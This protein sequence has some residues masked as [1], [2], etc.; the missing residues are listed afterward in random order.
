MWQTEKL[1]E[2]VAQ[3]IHEVTMDD[4]KYPPHLELK[5][6]LAARK[7]HD[8]ERPKPFAGGTC[9]YARVKEVHYGMKINAWFK[10][11]RK[12]EYPQTN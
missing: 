1:S 9:P 5:K 12:E 11:L 7:K 6:T 4:K 10:E 8:N 2:E 3:S